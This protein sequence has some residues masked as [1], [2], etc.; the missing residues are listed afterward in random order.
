MSIPKPR[1]PLERELRVVQSRLANHS[2]TAPEDDPYRLSLQRE[3]HSLRVMNSL[4]KL[5]S[6]A[7][8]TEA[9]RN[10]LLGIA[11]KATITE[12]KVSA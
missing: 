3:F 1:T 7:T 6:T 10:R 8:F 5:L 11:A 12:E 9:E 2:K 4:D